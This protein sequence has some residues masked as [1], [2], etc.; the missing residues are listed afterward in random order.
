VFTGTE[1]AR[2][3]KVIDTRFEAAEVI[4]RVELDCCVPDLAV[5]ITVPEVDPAA[6]PEELM[7][8]MLESD[9]IHCAELVMSLEVESE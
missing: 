9:E 6:M 4:L 7:L 2:G 8:A 3:D 5:I 1:A